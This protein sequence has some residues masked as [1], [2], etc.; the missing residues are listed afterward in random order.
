LFDLGAKRNF[1]VYFGLMPVVDSIDYTIKILRL[2]VRS[3]V[4]FCCFL[5]LLIGAKLI[6]IR[7]SCIISQDVFLTFKSYIGLPDSSLLATLT[8]KKKITPPRSLILSK[9][10]YRIM[11]FGD[12]RVIH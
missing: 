1:D 10:T 8:R 7:L 3:L 12:I 5:F 9:Y 2:F 6:C 11:V 4:R